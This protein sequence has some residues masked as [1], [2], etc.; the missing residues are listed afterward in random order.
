MTA[1]LIDGKGIAERCGTAS[2]R[3]SR[4]WRGRGAFRASPS[5]SSATIRRAASTCA[6]RGARPSRRACAPSITRCR[7][8]RARPRCWRSSARLNADPEVDGILVQLPLPPQVDA[9][10]VHRGDRSRQGRRRLPPAQRGQAD[11]RRA[12]PE[13]LHAA[14]LPDA[15]PLRASRY[16]R[17]RGRGGG[18]LQHRRQARRAAAPRR[19]LHGDGRAFAHARPAGDLPPRRH[20]R[21]RHRPGRDDPRRLGQARRRRDR[22]RHQPGRRTAARR[23]SSATWPSTRRGRSRA[24]SRPCPAASAR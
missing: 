22:C 9:Q 16:G 20:P 3:R 13:T 10:K 2:P 6:T 23:G 1:A 19:E 17:A 24:P 4:S 18:A 5:C 15:G 12:R 14:R 11:D 7:P 8:R 21:R